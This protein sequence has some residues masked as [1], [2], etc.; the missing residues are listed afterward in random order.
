MFDVSEES[1]DPTCPGTGPACPEWSVCRRVQRGPRP[2]SLGKKKLSTGV[3]GRDTV[4]GWRQAEGGPDGWQAV[5]GSLGYSQ[6]SDQPADHGQPMARPQRSLM[7][8]GPGEPVFVLLGSLR[9]VFL[10]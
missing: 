10:G 7:V 5:L 2:G 4:D 6:P 9:K 3:R 8:R 1:G